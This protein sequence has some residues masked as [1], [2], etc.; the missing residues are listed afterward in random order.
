MV[1]DASYSSSM[2]A[3]MH[4]NN[5]HHS[6]II[7]NQ[8]LHDCKRLSLEDRFFARDDQLNQIRSCIGSNEDVNLNQVVYITGQSGVGKTTLSTKAIQSY[9]ATKYWWGAA[10]FDSNSY[11]N[12]NTR[13]GSNSSCCCKTPLETIQTCLSTLVSNVLHQ[14]N[15]SAMAALQVLRVSVEPSH[16][17][18]LSSLVPS[19]AVLFGDHGNQRSMRSL[20]R[21]SNRNLQYFN[22]SSNSNRSLL[23]NVSNRSLHIELRRDAS[24]RHME[25]P[26]DDDEDAEDDT[27]S[28]NSSLSSTSTSTI[29][30]D[31]ESI[32]SGGGRDNRTS[33]MAKVHLQVALKS[34][35]LALAKVQ[36]VVLLLD[37]L[38][39]GNKESF[40]LLQAILVA[41]K[42]EPKNY[43]LVLLATYRDNAVT[44]ELRAF[45]HRL[46]AAS[47]TS[48][49]APW[50]TVIHLQ[51]FS[52]GEVNQM[53]M[54][55]FDCHDYSTTAT[56]S[57]S[58][59]RP[60]LDSSSSNLPL[61][62]DGDDDNEQL[63][64]GDDQ[65][66]MALELGRLIH[67]RTAGNIFFIRQLLDSLEAE[68]MIHYDWM[69]S[70]WKCDIAR[71]QKKT[72][73]SEN[74]LQVV[75]Q[76]IQKFDSNVQRIL[77]L[78]AC[79][80]TR[81]R[82]KWIEV[83][84]PAMFPP[85][86]TTTTCSDDQQLLLLDHKALLQKAC[87]ER[88][89]DDLGYGWYKFSHNKVLESVLLLLPEGKARNE[90]HWK[91]GQLL[92]QKYQSYYHHNNNNNNNNL[93]QQE[94]EAAIK[95][96]EAVPQLE[97][98]PNNADAVGATRNRR[99]RLLFVCADQTNL[100]GADC[101]RNPQERL[102]MVRLNLMAAEAA[103][104]VSAFHPACR[105][106]EA[107]IEALQ[108]LGGDDAN[109]DARQ[110]DALTLA[111][112]LDL[113]Q[114]YAEM[115]YCTG[116]LDEAKAYCDKVL[117]LDPSSDH[118]KV[119]C[120]ITMMQIL[121]AQANNEEVVD[122][123][124]EALRALGEK[125]PKQKS[126]MKKLLGEK[127]VLKRKAW[128]SCTDEDVLALPLMKNNRKA[129]CIQVM[130]SM[131]IPL[132]HMSM[133][134]LA[135]RILK[136]MMTL[137]LQFG[138]TK[139]APE[140]FAI[141]GADLVARKDDISQGYRLGKLAV[142]L[143]DRLQ[144]KSEQVKVSFWTAA[145]TFWWKEPLP[146]C[147]DMNID[148]YK[149]GM[150]VGDT[151]FAFY[152]IV[153]YALSYFNSGL[154]LRPL[155]VDLD[156]YCRQMVDYKQV[157]V[158]FNIIPCY[159]ATLN[160]CGEQRTGPLDM[161]RGLAMGMQRVARGEKQ[162]GEHACWSFLMQISFYLGQME[163]VA[164]LSSKLQEIDCGLFRAE[165]FY[166]TRVF[167]FALSAIER[168]RATK[169]RRFKQEAQ[170]H[171]ALI[172]KWISSG[173]I[174]LVH[175]GMLLRA[176]MYTITS[177]KPVPEEAIGL[178]DKAYTTAM[179]SGF[180]QDAAL[181]CQLAAAYCEKAFP[182]YVTPYAVKA[183]EQWTAWDA[184]VIACHLEDKYPEVFSED[185]MGADL[186]VSTGSAHF[187][188][189]RFTMSVVRKHMEFSYT[190][191]A[192]S[193]ASLGT[194]CSG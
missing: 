135:T 11:N 139:W 43:N 41:N 67:Q 9:T 142:A 178:Y 84:L 119:A 172:S 157:M 7:N 64:T 177:M 187:G 82:A 163:K 76:K 155:L 15:A 4:N 186:D 118:H 159:Q 191:I 31:D 85:T 115:L 13:R 179:R 44:D 95:Q 5:S 109:K 149:S 33:L 153:T 133:K 63:D 19:M 194:A 127:N 132:V 37:D 116:E 96:E 121:N 166:P 170:K 39:W 156:K 92:Y 171:T 192:T 65:V 12:N 140:A 147:L 70:K 126:K 162:V 94:P 17:K 184:V 143:V 38:Q 1:L 122:F 51:S 69:S 175:K 83:C 52:R 49:A 104:K 57:S 80:G 165:V 146:R 72:A 2:S 79:L 68:Q 61:L 77:Q 6:T 131:L 40:G 54:D 108:P 145:F 22:N 60:P 150:R 123:G 14:D 113:Y 174:N 180:L 90:L 190:D 193:F 23:G 35:F 47:T 42:K 25:I 73:V 86:T 101:C 27:Q 93:Q 120:F 91:L 89:L 129:A 99:S 59:S 45:Q 16:Q 189:S 141:A 71:V 138:L 46:D 8:S 106:C 114:R 136:R 66:T 29:G 74:V 32:S 182:E 98:H 125:I 28:T 169:K 137:T 102:G 164:E 167:F 26:E 55:L 36:K 134:D 128:I 103:A 183:F 124:L 48:L 21:H 78:C 20:Q 18:I 173:A 107:G 148:G 24:K 75:V 117:K 88:L 152:N 111:L 161:Q 56:S 34:F 10:S 81:I 176:E 53:L 30:D 181:T 158:L 130:Q 160:L 87:S 50:K 151:H 100:G 58:S 144:A 168:Y 112:K 154:P 110:P 185:S 62:L 105:Y 188:R 97:Q 3:S